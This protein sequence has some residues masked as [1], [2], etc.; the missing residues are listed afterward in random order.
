MV[1]LLMVVLTLGSFVIEGLYQRRVVDLAEMQESFRAWNAELV[2]Y[3]RW[4]LRHGQK[5]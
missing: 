4:W 1:V 5:L 2:H 3:D